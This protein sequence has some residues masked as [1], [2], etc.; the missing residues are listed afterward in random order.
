MGV[1]RD[2]PLRPLFEQLYDDVMHGIENE[3]D[4]GAVGDR[5]R[6]ER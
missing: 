4:L 1:N 6:W 5:A 2:S 3:L